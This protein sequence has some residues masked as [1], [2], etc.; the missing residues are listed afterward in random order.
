MS[1][2]IQVGERGQAQGGGGRSQSRGG[3]GR[4]DQGRERSGGG[5]SQQGGGGRTGGRGGRNPNMSDIKEVNDLVMVSFTVFSQLLRF[6][7]IRNF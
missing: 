1:E 4:G 6:I 3:G 7:S 5:R 2:W